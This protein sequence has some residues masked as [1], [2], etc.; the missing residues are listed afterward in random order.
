MPPAPFPSMHSD[1][2]CH[3]LTG[4]NKTSLEASSFTLEIS[5]IQLLSMFI[6]SRLSLLDLHNA[7]AYLGIP[8]VL[9]MFFAERRWSMPAAHPFL[10]GLFQSQPCSNPFHR[11][12]FT[13][14][15]TPAVVARRFVSRNV[16]LLSS[17]FFIGRWRCRC[18]RWW[19]CRSSVS[20]DGGSGGGSWQPPAV[21]GGGGGPAEAAS[22]RSQAARK[23]SRLGD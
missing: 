8:T 7:E 6:T 18:C 21:G 4:W 3:K 20:A 17:C 19:R 5:D 9:R 12:R 2:S 15:M 1:W 14:W 11:E 22:R 10:T 23:G 16:F 13:H